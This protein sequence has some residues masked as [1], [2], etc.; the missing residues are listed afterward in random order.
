MT[1]PESARSIAITGGGSGLG[2]GLVT[3]FLEE[4]AR[5]TVLEVSQ[6]KTRQLQRDCGSDVVAVC[7]DVTRYEDNQRAIAAAVTHAGGLDT[8]IQCAAITDWSPSIGEIDPAEIPAAFDEVMRTNV[9]GSL[10]GAMASTPEL[11]RTNGCMI[12]TLSTSGFFPGGQGA[13]YSLSK[14]AMVGL[15]RQLAYENAPTIRVNAVVPGAVRESRISGPV[16]LHQQDL[17]PE[18]V[19][20]NLAESV[21]AVSPLGQY[22]SAQDYAPIYSLLADPKSS[23]LATGSIIFWDTGINLIGHG[24]EVMDMMQKQEAGQCS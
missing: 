6:D 7:G 3:A 15:V 22:P 23:Q 2:R 16:A 11:R 8:F 10:L 20:P 24:R 9:L 13:L 12:F 14:H 5:V 19:A 1:I 4:G 18:K 17:Y 21:A